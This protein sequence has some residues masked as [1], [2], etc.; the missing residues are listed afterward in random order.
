MDESENTKQDESV[1]QEISLGYPL[2]LLL[3]RECKP[4][5]FD[6]NKNRIP[7]AG[8]DGVL[9]PG[10]SGIWLP[11]NKSAGTGNIV[12]KGKPG[13]GK[14]TL[15]LQIAFACTQKYNNFSAAFFPMEEQIEHVVDKAKAFGWEYWLRP[16][17]HLENVSESPSA[18]ELGQFLELILRQPETCPILDDKLSA[19]N[20]QLCQN[21]ILHSKSDPKVLLPSLSPRGIQQA[22]SRTNKLFW[23]RYRQLENFLEGAEWLRENR[24]FSYPAPR[25]VCLD[26]LNTFGDRPLEREE[27]FRIFDLFK[28]HK[29][30]GVFVL[31]VY[32]DGHQESARNLHQNMIEYLADTVI[33]LQATEDN[34]YYMR[35]VEIEKSR[36][37]HQI[38]GQH[39]FRLKSF[40]PKK[41][42]NN[43][44]PRQAFEIFPSLHYIVSSIAQP[45]EENLDIENK[46]VNKRK[47]DKVFDF[48]IR[49][50]E[51]LLP[52]NLSHGTVIS[53]EGPKATFKSTLADNFLLRGLYKNESVLLI[54]LQDTLSFHK[55]KIRFNRGLLGKKDELGNQNGENENELAKLT[56]I[57]NDLTWIPPEDQYVNFEKPPKIRETE[58][59][60]GKNGPRLIELTFSKGMLMAEEFIQTVR[61]V[62][63]TLQYKDGKNG[64]EIRA[65]CIG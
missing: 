50:I 29:I 37:Q 53:I 40:D 49:G 42:S 30:I 41:E 60:Y 44:S 19:H 55:E 22:D 24:I 57:Y 59:Q 3:N 6:S 63:D 45:N 15:A 1:I 32:E 10:K 9:E 18:E 54:E 51:M 27:I 61:D 48:G 36:Y 14:S 56:S 17:K 38:Y 8:R 2:D 64:R 23:E 4:Y 26:S 21:H 58:W 46:M 11:D 5:D 33:S 12:I 47:A 62:F 20:D 31:E 65:R 7:Q 52:T 13:T 16:I 25:V 28:R 34:G 43:P 39:P 35:Y